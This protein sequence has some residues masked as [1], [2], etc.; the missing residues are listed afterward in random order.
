MSRAALAM[1]L[2]AASVAATQ[3]K[4]PP[5]VWFLMADGKFSSPPSSNNSP[6]PGRTF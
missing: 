3:E 4:S 1:L 5:N 6:L 2:G